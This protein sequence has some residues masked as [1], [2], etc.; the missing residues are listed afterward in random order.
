MALGSSAPEIILNVIEIIGS[1][2][3][4]GDLGPGISAIFNILSRKPILNG[5]KPV[6]KEQLSVLQPSTCLL[7]S[8][9]VF[10]LFLMGKQEE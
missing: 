9:F 2:F 5:L 10:L 8:V 4:A 3:I 1:G 7:L 6:F